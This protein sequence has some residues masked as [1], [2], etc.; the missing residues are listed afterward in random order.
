MSNF[1]YLVKQTKTSSLLMLALK[2]IFHCKDALKRKTEQFSLL[3]Y[4][5]RI[6]DYCLYALKIFNA[7]SQYKI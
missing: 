5:E 2:Y 4:Q 7:I 6:V 1:A 3:F